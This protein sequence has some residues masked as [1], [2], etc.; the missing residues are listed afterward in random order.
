MSRLFAVFFQK[1]EIYLQCNSSTFRRAL[2]ANINLSN[3]IF[4]G[5]AHEIEE[6]LEMNCNRI[7]TIDIV[8]IRAVSHALSDRISE[9]E[10][11]KRLHC[12]YRSEGMFDEL[13]FQLPHIHRLCLY[14]EEV[15][16]RQK[17]SVLVKSFPNIS[18]LRIYC[19]RSSDKSQNEI[20]S[21]LVDGLPNL[22]HLYLAG[23]GI[24][25]GE[26]LTCENGLRPDC[27][28]R[29]LPIWR[30]I[31]QKNTNQISISMDWV[32][33]VL[34]L[35]WKWTLIV[36]ALRISYISWKFQHEILERFKQF[37]SRNLLF[38]YQNNYLS[39]DRCK[40][41]IILKKKRIEISFKRVERFVFFSFPNVILE[42]KC[43]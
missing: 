1:L 4:D 11:V 43:V 25:E 17:L 2:S 21:I 23:F 39:I 32:L 35:K 30:F 22:T 38:V 19:F 8:V 9:S 34:R 6:L 12:S 33:I 27:P 18:H 42:M 26:N 28:W 36:D 3:A 31:F 37:N 40:V 16:S 5:Y 29:M 15:I 20:V 10:K 13:D 14:F 24:F 41:I 7:E